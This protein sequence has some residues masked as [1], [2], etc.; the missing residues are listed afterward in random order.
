MLLAA[1]CHKVLYS[2]LDRLTVAVH[3]NSSSVDAVYR[4]K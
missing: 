3:K 2:R 1:A 4:I